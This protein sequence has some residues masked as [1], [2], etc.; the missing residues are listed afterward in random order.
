MHLTDY[1][2]RSHL[3]ISVTHGTIF[4]RMTRENRLYKV[5][6]NHSLQFA[7]KKISWGVTT[8]AQKKDCNEAAPYPLSTSQNLC[9]VLCRTVHLS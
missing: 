3:R 2:N 6:N 1:H 8:A 4:G 5:N 9:S 7:S